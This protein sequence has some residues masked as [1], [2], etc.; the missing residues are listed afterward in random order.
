MKIDNRKAKN[1]GKPLIIPVFIMNKGCPHQCIFCNQKISAGN[2]PLEL[3]KNIFKAEV[4]SYLKWN[5]DKT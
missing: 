2:Y 3:T 1:N 5:K 4:E